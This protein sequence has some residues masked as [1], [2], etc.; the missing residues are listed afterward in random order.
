[1]K[2]DTS[3]NKTR[4]GWT[5]CLDENSVPRLYWS[6][7]SHWNSVTRERVSLINTKLGVK[8]EVHT[9]N[10]DPGNNSLK[11]HGLSSTP[12]KSI[13]P[14]PSSRGY[15]WNL[16]WWTDEKECEHGLL[17]DLVLSSLSSSFYHLHVIQNWG[18]TDFILK[19][20][21]TDINRSFCI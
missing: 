16:V 12:F 5:C 9:L 6:I 20:L 11:V 18:N 2:E 7:K 17:V 13:W 10:L 1:M 14:S 19:L 3:I 15:M 21:Y 8:I 4:G